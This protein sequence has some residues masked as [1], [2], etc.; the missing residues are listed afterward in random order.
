VES[1]NRLAFHTVPFISTVLAVHLGSASTQD[2][3]HGIQLG[4]GDHNSRFRP[5]RRN[6]V[7][8]LVGRIDLELD[9]WLTELKWTVLYIILAKYMKELFNLTVYYNSDSLCEI[10][11]PSEGHTKFLRGHRRMKENYGTTV[12][13]GWASETLLLVYN[14]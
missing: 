8:W 2:I 7:H 10:Y 12:T 14:F 13:F 6:N 9:D 5:R 3:M 4:D 1:I 11:G